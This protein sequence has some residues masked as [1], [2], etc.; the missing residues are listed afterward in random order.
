MYEPDPLLSRIGCL[1]PRSRAPQG[2]LFL[3]LLLAAAA[4]PRPPRP[5]RL[6]DRLYFRVLLFFFAGAA[7]SELLLFLRLDPVFV[8]VEDLVEVF[9]CFGCLAAGGADVLVSF[10]PLPLTSLRLL[11]KENDSRGITLSFSNI[12]GDF[13]FDLAARCQGGNDRI[14]C[15][16]AE[17][18]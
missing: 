3:L 6:L 17:E 14:P 4:L 7:P 13:D 8:E 16:V 15:L 10:R 5:P 18:V 12:D 1:I 11:S 9:L 2:L